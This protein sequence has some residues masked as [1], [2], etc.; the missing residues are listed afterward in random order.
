MEPE[1]PSSLIISDYLTGPDEDILPSGRHLKEGM[2]VLIELPSLRRY[3]GQSVAEMPREERR[4]ILAE[5]RWCRVSQLDLITTLHHVKFTGIYCDGSKVRR[6][7][8]A[9]AAW[10]VKTYS[11][12][13]ASE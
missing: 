7:Y 13:P 12:P 6:M 11:I 3:D 1:I 8:A 10:I 9:H 4:S 5:A 2:I